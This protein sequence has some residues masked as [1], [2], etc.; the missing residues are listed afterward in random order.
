[1]NPHANPLFSLLLFTSAGISAVFTWIAWR[2]RHFTQSALPVVIFGSTLTW[3]SFT[4]AI[5]WTHLSRP[6]EFFWVDITYLGAVTLPTAFFVFSLFF[7]GYLRKFTWRMFILLSI[8]P[9]ITLLILWT[10][11]YHGLF[12]AGKRLSGDAAILDGG[13]IFWFNLVYSYVLILVGF[14]LLMNKYRN[15][16]ATYRRQTGVVLIGASIP[17]LVNIGEIVGILPRLPL[18]LTPF[19]FTL[20]GI[21]I[22]IGLLEFDF[23]DLAPV[24]RDLLVEKMSD[25]VIVLDAQDRIVDINPS[26]VQ[27]FDWEGSP[28]GEPIEALL[29]GLWGEIPRQLGDV[30][31][32]QFEVMLGGDPTRYFDL[33]IIPLYDERRGNFAGRLVDFR[34]IT[35]RKHNEMELRQAN[36]QLKQQLL[37]IENL[38]S[39][40]Q[41]L[42]TRDPLT[43]LFNRRYLHE[44]LERELSRAARSNAPLSLIMMDIDHFKAVND[45]Y[46]HKAGD[47]MLQALS[48][49]LVDRVRK[50]DIPCR[51]GG[52]EFL[53]VL[54]GMSLEDAQRRAE[55]FRLM[56]QKMNIPFGSR[57]LQA[58]LSAGVACYPQHGE[59]SDTLL[60]LVDE[61]L[62]SAKNAG[63]NQVQ[64]SKGETLDML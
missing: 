31:E 36:Q 2:R 27:I 19:A 6:N 8:E 43:G 59:D 14:I 62:Y 38:Q 29:L 26:A 23:L 57:H 55:E 48:R 30:L 20:T 50:E 46:G 44:T 3:W 60:R 24:A 15:S 35:S 56:F 1:M 12:F 10:D 7:S 33:H 58:T 64:L 28:I 22:T 41:E 4:Y 21:F 49:T 63:R 16:P 9:A 13:F 45:T 47:L 18:D 25:G 53:I 40:L 54:P 37:E 39:R 52:E 51:Y 11:P 17:W 61:A 5:H 34:D 32:G 42:A